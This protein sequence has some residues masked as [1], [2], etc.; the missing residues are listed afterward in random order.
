MFELAH[1]YLIKEIE[2]DPQ[3]QAL[4]AAQELLDQETRTYQRH[5]TLMTAERLAVI[6]PY[7]NELHFSAEAKTLLSE[8]QKAV[9][10]EKYARERRR[11]ITLGISV[12]VAIGMTLLAFWGFQSSQNAKQQ[13]IVSRAGAL[14]A[15]SVALRDQNFRL[16][17]LLGIEA[18]RM[19]DTIQTRGALLDAANAK[20]QL[21]QFISSFENNIYTIAF[22]TDGK[23]LASSGCG[24]YVD[25]MCKQGEIILWDVV[26][27]LRIGQPI[28]GHTR[29]V[30]DVAFSPDGKILAS[31]SWDGSILLWDVV[32]HEPIG[33][34]L[35]G[36]TGQVNSIA[37]SS[38]GKVLASGSSDKTIILWSV[39]SGQRIGKPLSGHTSSVLSVAFRPDGKILASGGCGKYV[40]ATC[41]QGEIILWDVAS[42][43]HID[44]PLIGHL[45]AVLTV[46]FSPDG[47][48]LASG[49]ADGMVILWD[50]DSHHQIGQPLER[51]TGE[52]QSIAFS[53]DGKVLASGS[54]DN[55]IILW[56]VATHQPIGPSLSGNANGVFSIAFS[57]D[58]KTLASASGGLNWEGSI[59][60]WDLTSH[61]SAGQS[62]P[63]NSMTNL[64]ASFNPDGSILAYGGCE[65]VDSNTHCKQ[66]E[67]ILWDMVK[68]KSIGQPL[69]AHTYGVSS[70]AFSPDGKILDSGY[71][72]GTIIF[73]DVASQQPIQTFKK[74]EHAIYSIAFSPDGKVFASSSGTAIN[75]WDVKT[76]VGLGLLP[77]EENN[78]V[79]TIA[80][81]SDGKIL[82]S[83]NGDSAIILWDVAKRQRID[84]PL[85]GHIRGSILYSIAFSPDG[86]ILASGGEDTTIFLWDVTSHGIIGRLRGHT[87]VVDSI[88][89]S[90]DGKTL[91]SSSA[92]NNIILWEVASR[93]PIGEPLVGHTGLVWSLAFSPDGKTLVSSS[94]DKTIILWN[95]NTDSWIEQS[96]R[97]A[98]SNFTRIEWER[99]FPN[100]KYRRTCDQW[101]PA[102]EATPAPS[103]MP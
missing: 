48:T 43:H 2:L 3:E 82:A 63:V 96:C 34:P 28:T 75:L 95:L 83:N 97:R 1:D 17:L 22:S 38:D 36:H 69:R 60:L 26:S 103:A 6:D 58:G 5:K 92:D 81:R 84:P 21:K 87:S 27:R 39:A 13:A 7:Q 10:E 73:W 55:T 88:A 30:G 44:L 91:A 72:D 66:S 16:S 101:P 46:A 100:E 54:F 78:F 57:S 74:D 65:D 25:G 90:P 4:K 77:M 29:E 31:A 79:S 18:F 33:S 9:R 51:H 62:L 64:R 67:I 98:G 24:E 15:Q 37:F 94:D 50:V 70:L 52:V 20:P 61:L 14:A 19:Q 93:Q 68:R 53:K 102:P 41:K 12:A 49:S 35:L 99:Y 40:D 8:S 71:L 47:I 45:K 11:N 80:F 89:F 56:D 23:T 42:R 85:T 86:K 59:V 32:T 76:H